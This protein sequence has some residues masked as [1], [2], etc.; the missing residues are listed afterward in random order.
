MRKSFNGLSSIIQEN[1]PG[2]LLSGSLFIFLNRTRNRVKL[3]YWDSDGFALWY[4]QLQK[5]RFK[6]LFE[7]HKTIL[8]RR[9]L[10][11]LLEGVTP[12]KFEPRFSLEKP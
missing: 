6:I 1:F 7:E 11:A 2:E 12:L 9:E 3:L 8:D 10:L 4:K 5:G